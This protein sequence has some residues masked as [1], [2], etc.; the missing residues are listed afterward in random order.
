M[1]Q[2]DL[3]KYQVKRT[4]YIV[5]ELSNSL[6]SFRFTLWLAFPRCLPYPLTHWPT[7]NITR[8][9]VPHNYMF[10][11]YPWVPNV[12]LFRYMGSNCQDICNWSFF[13]LG[14]MLKLIFFV[15]LWG[16][17]TRKFS[18]KLV[19]AICSRIS[20]FIFLLPWGPLRKHNAATC[21]KKLSRTYDLFM[22]TYDLLCHTYDLLCRRTTHYVVRTS[23]YLVRTTY[24]LVRTTYYLV[25]TTYYQFFVTVLPL[26]NVCRPRWRNFVKLLH[27]ITVWDFL[28]RIFCLVLPTLTQFL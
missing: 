22:R 21:E 7:L 28:I 12:T 4:W 16:P 19:A 14:T 15:V 26:A 11:F 17:L 13:P 6:I 10:H 23:Y 1:T 20:V 2:N 5:L 8:S 25:R 3:E 24:Y 18:L 27:F 9:N